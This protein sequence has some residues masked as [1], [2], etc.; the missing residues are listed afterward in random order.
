[1][2]NFPALPEELKAVVIKLAWE[3]EL[4]DRQK[5]DIFIIDFTGNAEMSN[6]SL[7]HSLLHVDRLFRGEIIRISGDKLLFGALRQ[8]SVYFRLQILYFDPDTTKLGVCMRAPLHRARL[9]LYIS[10]LSDQLRN[11]V[12]RLALSVNSDCLLNDQDEFLAAGI[13]RTLI[14]LLPKLNGVDEL[15][16]FGEYGTTATL[17]HPS[18][19]EYYLHRYLVRKGLDKIEAESWGVSGGMRENE[20][21][22]WMYKVDV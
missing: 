17:Y 19:V 3:A 9:D 12:T 11:N 4:D 15:A 16:I 8:S 21:V 7:H 6:A 20:L 14:C 22:L 2:F 5:K 1:M 10:Q 13:L 18:E